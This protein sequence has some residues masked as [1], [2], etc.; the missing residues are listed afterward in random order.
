MFPQQKENYPKEKNLGESVYFNLMCP[1][2]IPQQF[3]KSILSIPACSVISSI[4]TEK[5]P[6]GWVAREAEDCWRNYSTKQNIHIHSQ[7][8]LS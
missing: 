2:E 4:S 7:L 5:N 1:G 8:Y 6:E 3:L